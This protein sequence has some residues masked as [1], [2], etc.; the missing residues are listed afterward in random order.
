ML[1]KCAVTFAVAVLTVSLI[2]GCAHD[3]KSAVNKIQMG[4]T[5]SEVLE[6]V[7]NPNHTSR[8]L[9]NDV[10]LYVYD[11]GDNGGKTEIYFQ[12]GKVTYI[13]A[14][15]EDVAPSTSPQT[16]SGNGF[17]PVGEDAKDGKK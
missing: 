17:H 4:M 10:W 13:G 14:P 7:G 3:E 2:S 6:L 1:K 5:K 9:N 16:K 15:H 8:R 11:S 12:E